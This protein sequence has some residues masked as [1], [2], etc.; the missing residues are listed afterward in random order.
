MPI[1]EYLRDLR[2]V[3]GPRLLLMA[4]VVALIKDA[5]GRV[6]LQLRADDGR[7]GLP[8]GAIDPGEAPAQ[9]LAREVWEETGLQVV[10]ERIIGVFGGPELLRRTYPNGDQAEYTAI[11]FTCRVVGGELVCRDGESADLRW[12]EPAAMPPLVTP[13]PL[14]MLRE[15]PAEPVF[16]WSDAWLPPLDSAAHERS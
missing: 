9:A 10:P 4:G 12:F 13:Y 11:V 16:E 15:P 7:W 6:L 3:V 5:Q 14:E 1:S 8:A 2:A